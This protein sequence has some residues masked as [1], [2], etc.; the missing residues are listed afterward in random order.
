MRACA[1]WSDWNREGLDHCLM[2]RD[3]DGLRIE[4]LCIIGG[5]AAGAALR[6]AVRTDAM[7][8]TR[9]VAVSY[10]GGPDLHLRAD[11]RGRWSDARTGACLPA[12]QGCLDVDIA[13]T[14]ATN[15][16]PILRLALSPGARAEILAAYLPLPHEPG[17][18]IR[19][20]AARQSYT[21]LRAGCYRYE[22]LASGF[23]AEIEVDANGL[24]KDYPEAFRRVRP[25]Q[26]IDPGQRD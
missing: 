9:E 3:A 2:R 21:C 20:A 26:G 25:P 7:L 4:G 17:A 15:T 13:A 11:G 23:T 16:L 5:D 19:P 6:Y 22:S 8:R 18:P 14:P 1:R 24:V 10:I 12:L